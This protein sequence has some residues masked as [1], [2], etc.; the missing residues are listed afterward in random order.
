MKTTPDT[1]TGKG[2]QNILQTSR[3]ELRKKHMREAMAYELTEKDKEA[4]AGRGEP[5]QAMK[6]EK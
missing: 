3:E 4:L 6:S 5:F 2:R 1:S